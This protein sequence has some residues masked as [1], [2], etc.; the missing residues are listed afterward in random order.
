MVKL[1]CEEMIRFAKR[2]SKDLDDL[3]GEY[4]LDNTCVK[5]DVKFQKFVEELKKSRESDEYLKN[6]FEYFRC[7]CF[8]QMKEL[9]DLCDKNPMT[10]DNKTECASQIWAFRGIISSFLKPD[11]YRKVFKDKKTEAKEIM[12]QEQYNKCNFI[13]HREAVD[14]GSETAKA[15]LSLIYVSDVP[16]SATQ[17][18]MVIL[19][20]KVFKQKN[21]KLSA[22]AYIESVLTTIWGRSLAELDPLGSIVRSVAFAAGVT[23]AIG[24]RIAV[25]F[26]K[27]EKYSI[28]ERLIAEAET[29]LSGSKSR[30]ENKEEYNKLLNDFDN[31]LLDVPKGDQ[32]YDVY[33]RL[34]DIKYVVCIK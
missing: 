7:Q 19:L 23:E 28:R 24:W 34:S 9:D 31:F 2:T 14:E 10:G 30:K 4:D 15:A 8:F 21:T 13:I 27:N 11:D 29:F 3:C 16:I 1:S 25:E 12:T 32:L 33:D 20:G 26:V 6:Y 22:Q 17:I 18:K 5:W